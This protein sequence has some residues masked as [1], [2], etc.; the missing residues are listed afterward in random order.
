MAAQ[1]PSVSPSR[2]IIVSL[3]CQPFNFHIRAEN[4]AKPIPGFS[5][6]RTVETPPL[7]SLMA[8][9]KWHWP[10]LVRPGARQPSR[11]CSCLL[12]RPHGRRAPLP[13]SR[14]GAPR[15]AVHEA[16]GLELTYPWPATAI[17]DLF[18]K[19]SNGQI[20]AVRVTARIQKRWLSP[21][22]SYFPRLQRIQYVWHLE[23]KPR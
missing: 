14:P 3:L 1:L 11:W 20:S 19:P 12:C 23:K 17:E 2:Y 7:E 21:Y 13:P 18:D 16:G 5:Y 4:N 6:W 15:N 8:L 9:M 22:Q 10:H